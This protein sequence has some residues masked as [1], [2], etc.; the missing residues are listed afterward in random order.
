MPLTSGTGALQLRTSLSS[1]AVERGKSTQLTIELKHRGKA[2]IQSPMIELPLPGG[3][4]LV[5]RKV[6]EKAVMQKKIAHFEAVGSTLVIYLHELLP[7]SKFQIKLPLKMTW[8]GRFQ[9]GVGR[10]Y[11]YYNPEDGVM[12]APYEMTVR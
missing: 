4:E 7:A 2:A 10:A 3:V 12:S 1:S 11:P 6:L 5:D 9:S 8:S